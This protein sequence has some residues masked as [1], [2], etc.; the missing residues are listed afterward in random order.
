M[1]LEMCS[2][3]KSLLLYKDYAIDEVLLKDHLLKL[4]ERYSE[5]I[6][7]ILSA[8]LQPD[9]YV[10]CDFLDLDE[11][12]NSSTLRGKRIHSLWTQEDY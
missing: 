11:L 4:N 8:M 3:R 9:P 12:L 5:Q 7:L 10:R 2:V 1:V 6:G